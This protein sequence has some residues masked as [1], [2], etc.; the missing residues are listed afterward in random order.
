VNIGAR[1]GAGTMVDTWATVGSCAQI[2]RDVHLSGGVGIGGVL[3]PPAA[4]PVI[5]EDGAFVGSR[6]VVVEGV[7][8]GAEAVLGAGV[9]LTSSTAI[10]DVSGPSV[11]EHRG[12][13]PPRSVV[14]PGMRT[15]KFPAGEFGVPCALIIGQR[16]A[17][18]DRKLSLNQALRDFA[19]AV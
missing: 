1:V 4:S 16:T 2:G 11:V 17:S 10:L 9:V 5:I 12:E 7:H 13:V 6:V 14:I 3:E 18:T 15:K 19:V 8:V